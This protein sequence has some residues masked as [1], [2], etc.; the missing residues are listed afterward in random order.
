M[1]QSGDCTEKNV[2]KNVLLYGPERPA[3]MADVGYGRFSNKNYL[4]HFSAKILRDLVRMARMYNGHEV[5][6]YAVDKQERCPVCTNMAT[7]ERLVTNC[8]VCHGTGYRDSWQCLGDFWTYTDFGPVYH[9]ASPYGN[10]ENP[11]GT[12]TGIVILGAPILKDQTIIIF[13]ESKEVYKI[14][15]VEP[16]IVA[17]RGDIVAQIAQTTRVTPGSE[18]YKLID[19]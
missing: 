16:H 3:E 12:K 5:K 17:M 18:E 4:R 8:K 1:S 2:K 14:Y 11:N 10:T 6:I 9:M 7:G 15:D 13:I 19:W